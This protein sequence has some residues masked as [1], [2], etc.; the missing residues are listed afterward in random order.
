MSDCK[1][2][3]SDGDKWQADRCKLDDEEYPDCDDCRKEENPD[4]ESCEK[5]KELI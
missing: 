5:R 3:S 2:F 4:C 1:Y